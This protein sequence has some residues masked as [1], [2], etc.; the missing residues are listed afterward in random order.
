M[1]K[2]FILVKDNVFSKDECKTMIEQ[3][4]KTLQPEKIKGRNYNFFD[5]NYFNYI[6]RLN[7]ITEEYENTYSEIT[8]TASIWQ[9]TSLR[10]KHFEPKT[11]FTGWHSEHS[12]VNCY[13]LLGL[14]IYLSEH[15]CGTEFYN[16][17]V[18]KSK[19]GRICLFPASFTHTHRGQICPQNKN[20]YIIT[21]YISFVKKGDKE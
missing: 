12:Y 19:I 4:S 18:I 17:D 10:F 6:D 5:I 9:L 21:G 3:Y 7:S 2:N 20:R 1:N 8:K 11:G 15:N 14:Q 16:G 13:R